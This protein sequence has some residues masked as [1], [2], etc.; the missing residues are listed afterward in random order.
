MPSCD[1]SPT[2]VVELACRA[3]S[4]HNTQPWRW[5]VSGDRVELHADRSRQLGVA[6]P[7]GRNLLLSC[8]AALHHARVAAAS[9]GYDATLTRRPDPA[10]PDL[11]AVLEL[12]RSRRERVVDSDLH[13]L[14]A[15]RTDRRRFTAWPVE[16]ELLHT[17]CHGVRARGVQA[18]PLTGVAERVRLGV[19]VARAAAVHEEDPGYAAEEHGWNSPTRSNGLA[20]S[21]GVVAVC[22]ADDQPAAW[23]TAGE[24]MS[25]LWLQAAHAGLSV[26]PLSQVVEVEGTRRELHREVLGGLAHPQVL[27]RL[28]W[29]EM[30]RSDLPATPRRPLG[31]VLIPS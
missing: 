10:R 15:R 23:V 1:P 11:L 4:V 26:V 22:T 31:E 25:G 19:L 8:G 3:P 20:P 24:A 16:E 18:V 13:V 7:A 28:G 5:R 9:L 12:G 27:L 2:R 29:Q 6:D 17:L 14:L 30:G 21:D